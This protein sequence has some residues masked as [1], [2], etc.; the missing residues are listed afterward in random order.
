MPRKEYRTTPLKVRK[1][2]HVRVNLTP[3][4]LKLLQDTQR[5]LQ[6]DSNEKVSVDK[7]LNQCVAKTLTV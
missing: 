2:P 7:I 5:R 1:H 6:D 4:N 3:D